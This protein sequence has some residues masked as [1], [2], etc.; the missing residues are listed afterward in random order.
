MARN[1]NF[2]FIPALCVLLF[3]CG[4]QEFFEGNEPVAGSSWD[5]KDAKAFIVNIDDTVSYYDFFVDLRHNESYPYA[6]IYLFMTVNLPGDKH[7]QDTI[8]YYMQDAERNWLGNHSGSLISHHVLVKQNRRFPRK[9]KYV[10]TLRN[11]MRDN[12]LNG[13]T[14]VGITLKKRSTEN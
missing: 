1:R 8:G 12:P 3:S 9:G 2:L 11:G 4:E 14:D 6:N 5:R 7:A 13:I 10:F